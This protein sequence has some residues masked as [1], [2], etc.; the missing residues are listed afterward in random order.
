MSPT[1]RLLSL[2]PLCLAAA[3]LSA[4]DGPPADALTR[5]LL[6]DAE[7][8]AVSI[9]PDGTMFAISRRLDDVTKVTIHKR[10]NM[11]PIIAFDPGYGGEI[12]TLRWIDNQ[13]LIIGATRIG[14]YFK[15]A[16][17]S[18]MLTIANLDGRRPVQLP[19]NF[20]SMLDNDPDHIL[21]YNCG[22]AKGAK[23]CAIPEIR[24]VD[25]KHLGAHG[26]LVASG[27]ADAALTIDPLGKAGFAF[28]VEDDG[29]TRTHAMDPATKAW[30]L[31]NDSSKT[32]LDIYP[33]AMRRDGSAAILQSQQKQGPDLVESFDP[34]TAKRTLLYADPESD[35]TSLVY[36]F[37]SQ[38]VLGAFF[39]PTAP[40]LHLWRPEHPDAAILTELQTAF[41]G[42]RAVGVS[43]SKDHNLL[44]LFVYSDRD[45]GAYYLF[46]RKARK[47]SIITRAKPWAEPSQQATQR[48]FSL[49][50]R[51]GVL[52]HG[53]LTL[54]PGSS[55]KNLPL[56]VL[57]HG[58]PYD[59]A[60]TWGYDPE[61]QILGQHGYAV[62]QV[63]FR[64]SGGY[65]R[66]FTQIGERQWGRAMQDDISDATRW[67]I[68]EGIADAG[69][70][71]TFGASYG[72]Y[73]ALMGPIREPGLYRC[74]VGLS[75]VFDLGKMYNWGSIR[76]S[77]YGQAYLKRV[78][79]EDKAELA[80][81]SP[82]LLAD[83]VGVPVLLAH[84]TLD[85]RVDVKHAQAMEK[86][87]RK[88]GKPVELVECS[89]TGHS[90]IVPKHQL[91]FYARLLAFL[92]SNIGK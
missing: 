65:G 89:A 38:E 57:P 4:K 68:A 81:N 91:D 84:G 35:P 43:Q 25:L 40:R 85:G 79:G 26:E 67:A 22:F 90:I 62:L 41:P 3:S 50:A 7:F 80:A 36:S 1:L 75:G 52:L 17:F 18:P 16:L 46:D 63:N 92:D 21:V 23:G 31:I 29:T 15:S 27:P 10:E 70:I 13:R 71:C 8:Q 82:A 73:A 6:R 74:A 69:R 33:L 88:G 86:A 49:K 30:S 34:A 48:G 58:G 59:I 60:D 9:S 78:L 55:G 28:S 2:L 42:R 47:A 5:E 20:Y 66:H 64:G 56:V 76:R 53:L 19:G 83:K 54:P 12:T 39:E 32:G 61:L 72:G 14:G 37:D 45:P 44:V 51:D 11:E 77:D 24:K 87:L